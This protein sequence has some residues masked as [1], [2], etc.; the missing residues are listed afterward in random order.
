MSTSTTVHASIIIN[1]A[2]IRHVQ[3]IRSHTD[4]WDI[5][6]GYN[7]I[8]GKGRKSITS[9]S[10][11]AAVQ[12]AVYNL[13]L[14]QQGL[15]S[16]NLGSHSLRSGGAMAMHLA[17]ISDNTIKNGT[18]VIWHLFNVYSWANFVFLKRYLKTN[19]TKHTI[20]QHCLQTNWVCTNLVQNLKLCYLIIAV[21][22]HII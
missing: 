10:T 4:D 16:K 20:S 12:K 13:R 22:L 2:I 18:M 7:F 11:T 15:T 17:K 5:M 14:D 3:H 21:T 19:I 6:L 8:V 1:I 9:Y